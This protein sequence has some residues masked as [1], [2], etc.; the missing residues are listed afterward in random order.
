MFLASKYSAKDLVSKITIPKLIIHSSEDIVNPYFMGQELYDSAMSPKKFWEIKGGHIEGF[1][2]Y[3]KE[4][5]QKITELIAICEN[6]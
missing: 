2:F 1:K 3:E 5:F 6:H 4:Y